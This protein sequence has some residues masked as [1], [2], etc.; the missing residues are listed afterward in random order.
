MGQHSKI[1]P[2]KIELYH[3]GAKDADAFACTNTDYSWKKD[4]QP[5]REATIASIFS[6]NRLTRRARRELGNILS[7]LRRAKRLL[8]F[9]QEATS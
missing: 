8:S 4:Q 6:D 1:D 9:V 7:I 2:R 5:T 3:D